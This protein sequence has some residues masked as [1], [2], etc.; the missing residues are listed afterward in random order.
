VLPT[1]DGAEA[2]DVLGTLDEGHAGE[3]VDLLARYACREAEVKA[4][5]RL[6]DRKAG[7]P[8]EHLA[9]SSPARVTL[10][11]QDLFQ[12]VGEGGRLAA[13]L[14][15][16]AGGEIGYSTEPLSAL[17]LVWPAAR[18]LCGRHRA[19]GPAATAVFR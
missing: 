18:A 9:G 7:D 5:E 15:G 11:A 14:R 3:L 4:V 13:A 12:K 17:N 1:P 8:G 10:G 16:N 19:S 2:D 6:H